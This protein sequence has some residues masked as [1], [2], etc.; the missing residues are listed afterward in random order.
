M[1]AL[2]YQNNNANCDRKEPSD[3]TIIKK[4]QKWFEQRKCVWV[5]GFNVSTFLHMLLSLGGSTLTHIHAS[6]CLG[7][8]PKIVIQ[9]VES[10]ARTNFMSL[11]SWQSKCGTWRA[12]FF[13]RIWCG[14]SSHNR[15]NLIS[16]RFTRS[17]RSCSLCVCVCDIFTP[18]SFS[19][20]ALTFGGYFKLKCYTNISVAR[21]R[22][23]H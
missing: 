19:Q 16:F 22:M 1:E 8:S 10:L 9:R 23:P 20:I 15:V 7:R 18:Q 5:R 17:S 21:K 2:R 14:L 13:V 12:R 3:E 6:I 11:T 4:K